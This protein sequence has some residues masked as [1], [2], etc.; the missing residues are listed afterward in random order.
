MWPSDRN[1]PVELPVSFEW[2][3]RPMKASALIKGERLVSI[4]VEW[5]RGRA[6]DVRDMAKIERYVWEGVLK[7]MG[8]VVAALRANRN[9]GVPLR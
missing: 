8:P 4:E 9:R 1:D 5:P 3:K 6:L 2:N 7:N